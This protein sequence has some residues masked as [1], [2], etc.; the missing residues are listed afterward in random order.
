MDYVKARR[1][2]R[3]EIMM[4]RVVVGILLSL[5][6]CAAAADDLGRMFFTPEQRA[7]LDKTRKQNSRSE[8]D[9]EFKPPAPPLPQNVSVTGMIRRSDGKN[10]IWLNNR[11]VDE[12]PASGI[13]ARAGK[14]DNQVRLTLPDA[15][16]SVELKVG[17]TLE[18]VSGTIEENYVRRQA[19][20]SAAATAAANENRAADASKVTPAQAREPVKSDSLAQKRSARVAERNAADDA[21]FNS[22]AERK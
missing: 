8:A 12:R 5:P 16:T 2:R 14:R 10:T 22:D 11:V 20:E 4:A 18:V 15:G 6:A 13:V 3:Q 17:Q 21:R 9:R 7:T 19:S 1:A